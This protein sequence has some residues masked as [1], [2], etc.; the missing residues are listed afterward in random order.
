MKGVFIIGR[1]SPEGENL[2]KYADRMN[3]STNHFIWFHCKP[4]EPLIDG[5]AAK[6]LST[7]IYL[8]TWQ[9]WRNGTLQ[10]PTHKT[11]SVR[12]MAEMT[13]CSEGNF[14]RLL[15]RAEDAG[16]VIRHSRIYEAG[17]FTS[18]GKLTRDKLADLQ[19]DGCHTYKLWT[20]TVKSIFLFGDGDMNVQRG[21]FGRVIS[22]FPFLNLR[23][24]ILC[25]NQMEEDLLKIKPLSHLDIVDILGRHRSH[26]ERYI[27]PMTNPITSPYDSTYMI[28]KIE[29][30][31]RDDY[32]YLVNPNLIVSRFFDERLLHG[33][34]SRYPF[35]ADLPV[36]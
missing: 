12:D 10:T 14:R 9:N 18:T 7:F 11:A 19:L 32:G 13:N 3:W 21:T 36:E 22:L 35:I 2:Q 28:K 26:I 30:E 6:D 15:K 25:H 33:I 23:F 27:P 8:C 4:G 5:Y 31:G 17:K 1:F 16:L 34:N 29:L 20:N 24:N